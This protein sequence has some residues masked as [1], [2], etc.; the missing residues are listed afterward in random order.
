[1][2]LD[3]S[4][5]KW[6]AVWFSAVRP[7]QYVSKCIICGKTRSHR[8][9]IKTTAG[10]ACDC[11][12]SHQ[13][14]SW[15]YPLVIP[16]TRCCPSA[17]ARTFWSQESRQRPLVPLSIDLSCL[18]WLSA[19]SLARCKDCI[20]TSL[21]MRVGARGTASDESYTVLVCSGSISPVYTVQF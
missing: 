16:V 2:R 4:V 5:V 3:A 18:A 6:F 21:S 17:S 11:S 20:F 8:P 10:W 1:M 13:M 15:P 9:R 7:P 19:R 14:M 12:R